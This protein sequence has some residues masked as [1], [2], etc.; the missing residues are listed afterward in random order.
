MIVAINFLKS[1]QCLKPVLLG[2][3]ITLHL[4]CESKVMSQPIPSLTTYSPSK[5]MPGGML[6]SH[7]GP[8]FHG[9]GEV[10]KILHTG[11]IRTLNHF[12]SIHIEYEGGPTLLP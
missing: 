3:Y 4:G 10:A 7:R 12:F 1:V 11:L 8:G 6:C 9:S 5:F 2:G